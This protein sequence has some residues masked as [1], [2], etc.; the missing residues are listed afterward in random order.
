[1]VLSRTL[2]K[3]H[4]AA[5]GGPLSHFSPPLNRQN[6]SIFITTPA[7][8]PF[9]MLTTYSIITLHMPDPFV[10]LHFAPTNG[11][12][13]FNTPLLFMDF[14]LFLCAMSLPTLLGFAW[15]FFRS[16]PRILKTDITCRESTLNISKFSLCLHCI[17]TSQPQ[18]LH[19]QSY[20]FWFSHALPNHNCSY[21][22]HILRNN[23]P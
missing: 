13:K 21:C 8:N 5:R 10:F 16:V 3:P 9:N 19:M 2:V 18:Y 17:A 11:A 15:I 20:S 4:G 7:F 22:T 12:I 1:M 14:I 6:P 23:C